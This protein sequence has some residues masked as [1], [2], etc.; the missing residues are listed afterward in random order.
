MI[1]F[2]TATSLCVFVCNISVYIF[3]NIYNISVIISI[4][5]R[6]INYII[7][8]WMGNINSIKEH[9]Y[10][11]IEKGD[12]KKITKILEIYPDIIN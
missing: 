3:C 2:S 4:W 1:G 9:L 11:Y 10:S 12:I 5:K 8:T 7:K 6:N